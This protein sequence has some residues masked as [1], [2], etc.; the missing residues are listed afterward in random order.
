MYMI[1]VEKTINEKNS[2]LMKNILFIYFKYTLFK[3]WK[4]NHVKIRSVA[5]FLYK[6]NASPIKF[7][8]KK[9]LKITHRSKNSR[10]G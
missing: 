5:R 10:I 7:P 4:C 3:D 9:I 1:F 8:K 6:I 2:K